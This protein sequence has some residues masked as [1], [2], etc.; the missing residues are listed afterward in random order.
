M[1]GFQISRC[2]WSIYNVSFYKNRNTVKNPK[3]LKIAFANF[4][5]DL[6]L[7]RG[8]NLSMTI[9]QGIRLLCLKNKRRRRRK[10]MMGR[11]RQISR[12]MLT[13]QQSWIN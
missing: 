11:S 10:S 12:D 3:Y 4:R 7:S 9:N 6:G 13:V 1:D 2:L 5:H 8:K